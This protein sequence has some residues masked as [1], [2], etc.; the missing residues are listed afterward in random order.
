MLGTNASR[1]KADRFQE[2]L[3]DLG[4]MVAARQPFALDFAIS[5]V[6]SH[7]EETTSPGNGWLAGGPT[8]CRSSRYLRNAIA[9]TEARR[10]KISK[11]GLESTGHR[12]Q[13]D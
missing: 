13:P 1:I 3:Y 4:R 8:A 11:G 7:G 10:R 9:T 5:H 6:K 2:K 12:L